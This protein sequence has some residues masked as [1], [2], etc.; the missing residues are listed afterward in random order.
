MIEKQTLSTQS[1]DAADHETCTTLLEKSGVRIVQITSH[2]QVSPPDF[3]YDQEH[4]E[5]VTIMRGE[6]T[7]QIQDQPALTLVTG[8]HVHLP[9]NCRHRVCHTSQDCIWLAVH[10][11]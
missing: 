4:E 7:L 10:F 6:A 11:G 9:A 3:W 1:L 2:G 5:W 8:N